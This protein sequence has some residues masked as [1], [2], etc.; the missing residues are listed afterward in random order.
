MKQ[1]THKREEKY[2]GKETDD[3]TGQKGTFE[4]AQRGIDRYHQQNVQIIQGGIG[5]GQSD[6]GKRQRSG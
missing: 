4:A 6:P 3:N 5:S 2:H 1:N